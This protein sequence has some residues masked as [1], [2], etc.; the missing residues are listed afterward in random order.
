MTEDQDQPIDYAK[1]RYPSAESALLNKIVDAEL[2]AIAAGGVYIGGAVLFLLTHRSDHG[3]L[4][5]DACVMLSEP[6]E[7]YAFVAGLMFISLGLVT[8]ALSRR[9]CISG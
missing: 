7:L 1:K 8:K 2:S 3:S 6:F 4:F 5:T 9:W